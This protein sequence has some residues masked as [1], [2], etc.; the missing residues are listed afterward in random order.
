MAHGERLLRLWPPSITEDPAWERDFADSWKT[1][2]RDL[3]FPVCSL[4]LVREYRI[5]QPDASRRDAGDV[6]KLGNDLQVGCGVVLNTRKQW[7]S[8]TVFS[9]D[10]KP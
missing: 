4:A 8:A 6:Q 3:S 10:R 2:N 7:N 9:S 1:R 5:R